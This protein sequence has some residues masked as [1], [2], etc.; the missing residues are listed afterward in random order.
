VNRFISHFVQGM[1]FGKFVDCMAGFE[2]GKLF[3]WM[4][5]VA[6]TN[7]SNFPKRDVCECVTDLD[8]QI[9]MI[10]FESMSFWGSWGSSENRFEPKTITRN[11][12]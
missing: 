8:Y 9:V 5:K 3:D 2:G 10:I 12:I 6:E 4:R 7:Y 1:K 11:E